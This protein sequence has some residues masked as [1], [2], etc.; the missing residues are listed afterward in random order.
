MIPS[1][2]EQVVAARVPS[3]R[4]AD[5]TERREEKLREVMDVVRRAGNVTAM[6]VSRLVGY[7]DKSCREYLET[8]EL[9]GDLVSFKPAKINDA[10]RWNIAQEDKS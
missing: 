2:V 10:R 3:R 1:L 6:Q 5:T 9:R 8:L 7:S 4:E